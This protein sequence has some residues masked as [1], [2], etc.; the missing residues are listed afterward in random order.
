MTLKYV[1]Y[2]II[3][4]IGIF[5]IFTF[6]DKIRF[7]IKPRESINNYKK[8]YNNVSINKSLSFIYLS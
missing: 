8:I 1:N 2:K 6:K 5:Y 7:K 3:I 4:Y